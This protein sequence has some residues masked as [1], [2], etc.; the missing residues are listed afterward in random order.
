MTDLITRKWEGDG[1]YGSATFSPCERYRYRL[2]RWW[3][4]GYL[5]PVLMLNP[6]TATEQVL[7]PTITRVMGFAKREGYDGFIVANIFA[8]R[9]T[10]PK[11]MMAAADP[12]GPDND[13]EIKALMTYAAVTGTP[14]LCGWG[15][16]GKHRSR[17]F[18]MVKMFNETGAKAVCLKRTM[19]GQ[20]G[21]PLYIKADAPFIGW[22][23]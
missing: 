23:A 10:N 21:H 22:P 9:A 19:D 4:E 6:S 15:A 20:P 7:D 1:L 12:V 3:G 11:D 2:E 13:S 16:H 18:Q 17:D 8:F 14:V 5:L